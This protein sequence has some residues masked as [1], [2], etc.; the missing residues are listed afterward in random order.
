MSER[1][2][3]AILV[4]AGDSTRMG[5]R[6]SKQL[7]PLNGRPAIEYTIRAFQACDLIDEII[8]VARPQDID[9]IAYTAFAF[10]KVTTVTAGGSNRAESVRKGIHA[11]SKR[12][13][14]YAIHDGARILISESEIRRVLETAYECGA[15]TLGTPVTDTVKVVSPEMDILSTPERSTLYAVQTPQVFER[16]LYRRAMQN[17][18]DNNLTV[19]DDCALVEA[20]GERVRVVRGEYSNIKL[21]TPADITIAEAILTKRKSST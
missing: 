17:A 4:A 12:A 3:S 18:A 16:E 20:I 15:A 5:Y 7:I 6:M 21:T 1:Y 10:R 19:T 9:D 13:T 8:V 14:H 2:T 11:A